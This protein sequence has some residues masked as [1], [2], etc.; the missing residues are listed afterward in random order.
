MVR[1]WTT[2]HTTADI[3]EQAA[4]LRIPVAPVSSGRDVL[5]LDHPRIR[6]VWVDGPDRQLRDAPPALPLRRRAHPDAR[7]A[8]AV[9]EHDGQAAPVRRARP[10]APA[11]RAPLPLEGITVL[12]LTAWWAGPSGAAIFA[13]L[14]ADVVHVE[15]TRRIDGMRTAGG[16]FFSRPQWWEYSAFFL[17]ANVNKYDV[18][19]TLDT[20]A[21]P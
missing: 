13:S 14:G 1:E 5:E 12:D 7:P 15:S 10:E 20:P 6:G 8:P 17:S 9:G 4:L 2:Q 18:T 21:G 16:M 19:L 3:V 11:G